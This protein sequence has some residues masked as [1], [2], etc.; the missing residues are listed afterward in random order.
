[1]PSL[2]IHIAL[3]RKYLKI[4]NDIKDE[5]EFIKGSL[6]PDLA[7]DRIKS[8]Y[9]KKVDK[10]NL[11]EILKNKVDLPEYLAKT[12]INTDYE[13]GYFFHLLTDF[14][15]FNNFF[16]KNYVVKTD[17]NNF[18]KDLYY[19]YNKA[20]KY[21]INNYDISYEPFQKEVEKRISSS[22]KDAN[23]NGEERQNIIPDAHLDKFINE[24]VKEDISTYLK[25]F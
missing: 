14:L 6:A 11:E 5:V 3:A 13:K 23:Y 1:M 24:M 2:D 12:K 10:N 25:K 4:H 8:H 7:I 16:D 17:Y 9:T 22:Q 19:S 20:H 18:K 15:F 21:L